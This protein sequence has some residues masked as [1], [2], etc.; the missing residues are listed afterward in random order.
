MQPINF[1]DLHIFTTA[2]LRTNGS[3]NPVIV[4][5]A[6]SSTLSASQTTPGKRRTAIA[7]IGATQEF[8]QQYATHMARLFSNNGAALNGAHMSQADF[9][10]YLNRQIERAQPLSPY[11]LNRRGIHAYAWT[12]SDA[13]YLEIESHGAPIGNEFDDQGAQRAY[14]LDTMDDLYHMVA[15]A[16]ELK[17]RAKATGQKR[18]LWVGRPLPASK[19]ILDKAVA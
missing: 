16:L 9:Y 15:E 14:P 8:H 6:E 5:L 18:T 4:V 11:T 3:S 1:H 12:E 7:Y 17:D 2:D 10:R 19:E 13:E